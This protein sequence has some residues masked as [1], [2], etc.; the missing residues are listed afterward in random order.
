MGNFPFKKYCAYVTLMIKYILE[1]QQTLKTSYHTE[2]LEMFVQLI[3]H[4]ISPT[5]K[6]GMNTE[7]ISTTK[8]Y[9]FSFNLGNFKYQTVNSVDSRTVDGKTKICFKDRKTNTE[10]YVENEANTHKFKTFLYRALFILGY[11]HLYK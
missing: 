10:Q 2:L 7:Y 1:L 4:L 6:L 8:H 3:K 9:S 11:R 5:F